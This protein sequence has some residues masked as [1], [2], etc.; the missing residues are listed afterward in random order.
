TTVSVATAAT[1][2]LPLLPWYTIGFALM[3]RSNFTDHSSLPVLDSNARKRASFAG[4]NRSP[5][6]V[7]VGPAL[8]TLPTSCLPSGRRSFN[9]RITCQAMSPVLALIANN[10]PH[11]GVWHGIPSAAKPLYG[12]GPLMLPRS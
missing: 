5:P 2:C 10:L 9:P 12:P 4:T 6:A 3:L 7:D 8:P 1:Y 11:G